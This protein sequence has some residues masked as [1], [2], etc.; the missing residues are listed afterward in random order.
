MNILLHPT[1]FPNIS[2]FVGMANA[3]TLFF[4]VEDN[5]QKQTYR[6]R[7]IIY[8]ANRALPLSIPIVFSQKN[9]QKFKDIKIA[10]DTNWQSQH[11]KS[12]QSA[13]S[14][15]PFFEFYEDEFQPLFTKKETYLLDFN[16]KCI[17]VI[18]DCLPLNLRFIKTETFQKTVDDKIDLRLLVN[19]AHQQQFDAYTQV[20]NNKHGF[21]NNLSILDLLFNEGTNALSYLQSQK[22]TL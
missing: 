5:Y 3:E 8:G 4:E 19:K 2:H 1:Y 18:F 21:I 22:L 20:F 6:N 12:I 15:S 13:Y 7:T 14:T 9:R 16:L 10:N 11:W 17:E